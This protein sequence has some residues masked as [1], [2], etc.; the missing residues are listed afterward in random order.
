MEQKP[1]IWF[2]TVRCGTGTDIF[3]ET[4]VH[5]LRERGVRAEITWLPLRAEYAPWSVAIPRPP[6]WATV[7]H[8]NTWLHSRFLPKNLPIVATIHHSIHDP[9]LR[10]YKG[11][12]RAAYHRWWIAPNERRVLKQAAHITAASK[13]AADIAKKTLCEVTIQV[14]Y[15]GIEI[16]AF[17]PGNQTR[18]PGEP[19]RLLYVGSWKALK[20]VDL[21]APIMRELGDGFILNYTGGTVAEKAKGSMP[22]NMYDL[23]RLDKD[24]VIKAMQRSDALLLPSR[25]EG[26][27]LVAAEAMACGL[28]VICTRRSSL[29]EVVRDGET[30]ILCKQDD[31][32]DFVKAAKALKSSR[33]NYLT[34]AKSA[35]V[36]ASKL[37]SIDIMVKQYIY[38]YSSLTHSN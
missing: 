15:N 30:G 27:G 17:Q 33:E 23:G 36:L 35:H 25:S 37:F 7:A 34:Y 38:T 29:T 13:Y 28:P 6:K 4:L 19:F 11:W 3:T 20:G 9:A 2:P 21:L 31:I 32:N 16:E 24:G 26:F 14:V 1:A 8:V 10:P 5:K 12:L 18:K 22:A